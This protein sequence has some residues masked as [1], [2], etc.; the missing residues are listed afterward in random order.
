LRRSELLGWDGALAVAIL[1]MGSHVLADLPDWWQPGEAVLQVAWGALFIA[2]GATL[3][4]R[5]GLA[6]LG[7]SARHLPL[8]WL[9]LAIALASSLWSLDPAVTLRRAISMTGTTIL[10]I[11]LGYS[12]EPQALA[13][14]LFISLVILLVTSVLVAVGAPDYGVADG[15]WKGITGNRNSLAMMTAVATV[16]F[17]VQA[18]HG[19]SEAPYGFALA[20]MSLLVLMMTG[21]ATSGLAVAGGVAVLLLFYLADRLRLRPRTLALVLLVAVVL[22][23]AGLVLA[24]RAEHDVMASG[25]PLYALE[26]IVDPL[27]RD[28]TLTGRTRLWTGALQIIGERPWSGYGFGIVF[29][30]GDQTYLPH[31]SATATIQPNAHNGYINVAAE[32]GLPAALAATLLLI[33]IWFAAARDFERQRSWFP[34]LAIGFL[35]MFMVINVTEAIMFISRDTLWMLFVAFSLAL[36]RDRMLYRRRR[37]SR[38]RRG[39]SPGGRSA[40]SPTRANNGGKL[41]GYH[42]IADHNPSFG[43]TRNVAT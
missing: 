13:R 16:F 21:S 38:R 3:C 22:G 19:R 8:L 41:A 40:K 25:A 2:G 30:F 10:G 23:G 26:H 1:L 29:G 27:E 24:V 6:W 34:L 20:A 7:W 14:I 12:L 9:V 18:L 15:A 42:R 31:V 32:I 35:F 4:F 11:Y 39:R 36:A 5:Y 17:L 28:V 37:S 33:Q 43:R